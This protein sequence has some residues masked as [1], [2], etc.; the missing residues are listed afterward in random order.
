[1]SIER[2]PILSY[3]PNALHLDSGGPQRMT[4][5]KD[6][7]GPESAAAAGFDW[8][9]HVAREDALADAVAREL[10]QAKPGLGREAARQVS[11]LP[12][13]QLQYTALPFPHGLAER[14]R[15]I[16]QQAFDYGYGQVWEERERQTGRKAEGGRRLTGQRRG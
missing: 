14:V 4:M 8:D 13:E 5:P 3:D 6:F 9:G 7:G 12:I 11:R 16:L 10:K 15:A 2:K 1:M